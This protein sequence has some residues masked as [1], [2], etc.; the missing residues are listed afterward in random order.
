MRQI[1]LAG[2]TG[3]SKIMLGTSLNNLTDFCSIE[4]TIIITDNNV[5]RLYGDQFSRYRTIVIEA[6]EEHKTL[7]TVHNIY[8]KL[9]EL[10]FDRSSYIVGIGGGVVC[11]IAGFVAS[12]YLRGLPFGFAP[13]TLLAQV[14]ASVGGKNGVNF[15][16]YKNLIGTIN[17][18]GFVMCDFETIKTLPKAELKNGF[19]EVIKHALIGNKALFSRIERNREAA[20]SLDKD[21]INR[22]VYNSVKVKTGIVSRDETEK[23]ERRKLNFG[24]TFGHALEK[25]TGIRHGEAVSIGMFMEARL[26]EVKGMLQKKDVNRIAHVLG[27]FGL[28]VSFQGNVEATIDAIRKD[29]KR[30]DEYIHAILLDG[31]G[32]AVIEKIK[33]NVIKEIAYD[34]C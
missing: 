23:G 28:P 25:T 30:E 9:L 31:I 10:E 5:H 11:D 6:G 21:T 33:I 24:H 2:N 20:L 15:K 29:K 17:Q 12:T 34:M 18:P 27:A 19:A 8:K 16:G 22:I 3:K 13:T 14:D 26:S 1:M 32:K 4:K 7:D